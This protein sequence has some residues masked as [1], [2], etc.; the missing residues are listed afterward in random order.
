MRN[1]PRETRVLKI[2]G[3]FFDLYGTLLIYG[4][5]SAAWADW[6]AACYASLRSS[7]LDIT[8]EEFAGHCD[9]MFTKPEPLADE[10]QLTVYERRIK[11][12]A[13]RLQLPVHD[14]TIRK[15]AT[16]SAKAWQQHILL[17]PEA[18]PL[19]HTL[20]Q[21]RTLALITNFD[22]PPFLQSLL[23]QLDLTGYFTTVLISGDTG[24]KKPHPQ[25]FNQAL[26]QT[27]LQ[28]AEVIYVG[29][30]ADDIN[31]A[32]AAGV[33]PIYI[34]RDDDRGNV[35]IADFKTGFF[36]DVPDRP[37]FGDITRISRLSGLLELVD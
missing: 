18:I 28:P 30:T 19:L 35:W 10:T 25:M 2:K 22:H 34:S 24:Y 7:G 11:S 23:D 13:L 4:D 17:D 32:C 33:R 29:D 16:A 8:L 36:P 6:L 14:D 12:V 27:G 21:S 26:R 3:V 20:Q 15:A 31:G 5:M 1:V 9:G 37:E